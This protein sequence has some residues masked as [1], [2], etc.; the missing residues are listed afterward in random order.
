VEGY[1]IKDAQSPEGAALRPRFAPEV[2]FSFLILFHILIG[3]AGHLLTSPT[4]DGFVEAGVQ[5][6]FFNTDGGLLCVD[7]AHMHQRTDHLAKMAAGTL[8][9]VNLDFH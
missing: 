1:V 2:S 8:L 5:V 6:I 7:H 9:L 4:N 3:Q